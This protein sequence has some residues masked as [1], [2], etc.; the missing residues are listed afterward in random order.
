VAGSYEH[1]NETLSSG[2]MEL[3]T[4]KNQNLKTK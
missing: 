2:A 4:I 3:A 1:S